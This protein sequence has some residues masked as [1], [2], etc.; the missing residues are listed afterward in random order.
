MDDEVAKQPDDLQ[1]SEESTPSIPSEPELQARIEQIVMEHY[2]GPFPHP[3]HLERYAKLY[4]R[5][6]EI[7]FK[8]FE[9]QSEHRRNVETIFVEGTEHRANRGQWLAFCIVV[10]VILAGVV[11]ILKG[12]AIAGGSVIGVA[13]S[14]GVVL[15]VAGAHP[16]PK[17][18]A[19]QVRGNSRDQT[20]AQTGEIVR[21]PSP[22][23]KT[24]SS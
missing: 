15:Y 18:A 9:E 1:P 12:Q 22:D 17:P 4:P 13:F 21:Q 11:A 8:T 16:R 24:P 10:L 6:P 2:S 5:A 14:G 23:P 7:I 20:R 3:E 19:R